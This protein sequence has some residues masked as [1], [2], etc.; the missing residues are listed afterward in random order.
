MTTTMWTILISENSKINLKYP[1]FQEVKN[2][3]DY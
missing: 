2:D 3:K 1:I